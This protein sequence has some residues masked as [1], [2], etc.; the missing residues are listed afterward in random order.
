MLYAL[1]TLGSIGVNVVTEKKTAKQK[2]LCAGPV[3]GNGAL[4]YRLRPDLDIMPGQ[5]LEVGNGKNQTITKEEA[6][7][8]LAAPSWEFREVA[9]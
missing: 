6:E 5:L 8:L 2:I 7:L 9:E 4:F 3:E 1:R